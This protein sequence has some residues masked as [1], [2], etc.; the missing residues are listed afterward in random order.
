MT[1]G[2]DWGA[3][4]TD[5][6]FVEDNVIVKTH[7]Y[8]TKDIDINGLLML[9]GEIRITGSKSKQLGVDYVDEIKAIGLGGKY[10][11]GMDKCLVVSLGTGCCIVNVDEKIK[12]V[13]GTGVCGGTLL[14]LSKQLCGTDDLGEIERLASLGNLENVDLTV[15]DI[16]GEGIG[17]IPAE[18]T[19]SNFGKLNNNSK[20]DNAL[21]LVNMIAQSC[22]ML[23]IFAADG[24]KDIILTG[25]LTKV[26]KLVEIMDSIAKIYG[27]KFIVPDNAGVATAVGAAIQ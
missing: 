4:T 5:V 23:A 24:Y 11:S 3:S 9:D 27:K 14:G 25:K 2:I 18:K 8:E 20:E 17:K 7:S 10:L 26:K 22:A 19:A 15:K 1:I 13:G 6:V 12:H 21:G 16:I